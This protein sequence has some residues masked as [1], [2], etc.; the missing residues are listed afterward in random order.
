MNEIISFVIPCYGSENTI[1]FVIEE[2]D[3]VMSHKPNHDYEI[4]CVNDCSPDNVWDVL[5]KIII[6]NHRVVIA[7]LTRNMGKHA[8][9]M[10][11]YSLVSGDIVVNLDDDGQCPMPNLWALLDPL[12]NGYDI[13]IAKYTVKKQ[14]W[15]KSFGSKINDKMAHYLLGRPNDMS[16]ENFSA[17]KRFAIEEIK[18]YNNPYTYLEG[19]FHR[20]T[21][22]I[23]NVEMEQRERFSGKGN[24]T[25][26]KSIKLWFNG[27]TAFS[28]KPLQ[29]ASV[30]GLIIALIGFISG[31]LII[32]RKM[33]F[34]PNMQM[35]YPSLIVTLLFIGGILMI[36]LG[37]LG[38][39]V[40]R[41]YIS[42]NNSPQ[43]VIRETM[44]SSTNN[45]NI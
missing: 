8:A 23:I 20:T 42:I 10:A 41:I 6:S 7:D 21:S 26:S 28:V 32:I 30:F 13:S 29:I 22:R 17:I 11:G 2:I 27:F 4:I 19:L 38:E 44:R 37:L 14:S 3:A 12:S 15:L 34:I 1:E 16:V 39:Y 9:V 18:K 36:M 43:Y 33:F 25:F 24:F 35:G 5:K 40:G 31:V 45:E